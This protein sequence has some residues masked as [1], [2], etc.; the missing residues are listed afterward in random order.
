M[1][2]QIVIWRFSR[3]EICSEKAT[4]WLELWGF[5]G[6][7]GSATWAHLKRKCLKR[8][9]H[10]QHKS[11]IRTI[12]SSSAWL[13]CSQGWKSWAPV[14]LQVTSL[15]KRSFSK[16]TAAQ[17]NDAFITDMTSSWHFTAK[18]TFHQE[19][20][21]KNRNFHAYCLTKPLRERSCHEFRRQQCQIYSFFSP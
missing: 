18:Q 2:S 6:E 21:G 13:G 11:C 10:V 15:W 12:D 20:T 3:S 4:N 1:R 8:T 19:E 7:F 14:K 5:E 17:R 16:W 9:H